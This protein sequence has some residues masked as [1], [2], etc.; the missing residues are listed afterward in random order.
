[1]RRFIYSAC[2]FS[3]IIP[4]ETQAQLS[5]MDAL[6]YS[7]TMLG[8]TARFTAM[9]GAFCAVGADLSTLA[10]NPAGIAVYNKNQLEIT[11]GLTLQNTSSSYNGTSVSNENSKVNLQ[12]IGLVGTRK[13]GKEDGTGWKSYNFG[14]AYNRLNNFN[15][16]VTISG[17]NFKNT[18]LDNVTAAGQGTN[19]QNLDPFLIGP[20]FN[21]YLLDTVA[22][23]KGSNYFNVIHPFL[24]GNTGNY[25]DQLENITT[26][27]SM[28]EYDFSV[29]G[30]YNDKL[31]IGATLGIVNT[32]YTLTD[33]Y[34]ETTHFNNDTAFGLQNYS[35]TEGLTTSGVGYNF[36]IGFIYRIM[37]WLR[38]GGAVHSPTFFNMTDNFS[39]SWVANYGPSPYTGT[40]GSTDP[41]GAQ[42]TYSYNLTT[43]LKAIGGIAVIINNQGI[44]SADYEYVDYSS[45]RVNSTDP[46]L[47]ADY[48]SQVNSA[49]SQQFIQASN[50]KIGAE[51]VL[52]PVSFRAGYA[53]YGNPFNEAS[54]GFSSPRT[55]YSA[56]VGL[57]V[58]NVFFDFSYTRTQYSEQYQ[59]YGGANASTLNTT[60]SNVIFTLGY[61]FGE[62]KNRIPRKERF[63]PYPPPPPP[64]PPGAY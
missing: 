17:Y 44:L 24:G 40:G 19:Y 22:G 27:G 11:P 31:F 10:Y 5:Q 38:I 13:V 35:L 25:I 46:S 33:T 64:P 39:T 63:S 9:G 51:W 58:N 59:I 1:M 14:F 30:N 61:T 4:L 52:Y 45:I 56:G 47:A 60:I 7:T 34:T 28:G 43:P 15:D 48:T 16:N 23:T 37:D 57:K 42:A 36:K 29:G 12:S 32:D 49:I 2:L 20:A 41:L 54:V 18:F 26:T 6:R 50:I 3:A 53:L 8:G 21:T 55:T 62:H